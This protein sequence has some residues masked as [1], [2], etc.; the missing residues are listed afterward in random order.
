MGSCGGL[1]LL[2]ERY[3]GGMEGWRVVTRCSRVWLVVRVCGSLSV[4]SGVIRFGCFDSGL[5]TAK[6]WWVDSR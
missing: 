2:C 4:Y 5:G 3:P 6:G 1:G